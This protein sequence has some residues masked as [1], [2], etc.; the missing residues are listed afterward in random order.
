MDP[1]T[2][3]EQLLELT[4]PKLPLPSDIQGNIEVAHPPQ[5]SS[6]TASGTEPEMR[7]PKHSDLDADEKEELRLLRE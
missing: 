4:E 1:E 3:F 2:A 5:S 6:G 7:P